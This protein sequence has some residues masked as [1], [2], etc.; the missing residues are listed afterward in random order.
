MFDMFASLRTS[1][2]VVVAL[3]FFTSEGAA[4]STPS[5]GTRPLRVTRDMRIDGVANS[6][7]PVSWLAVER[8]GGIV[9]GQPQDHTLRFF[10]S[11]GALVESFGRQG[12]GP[13]EFRSVDRAG[14]LADTLW[15]A[16]GRQPRMTLVSPQHQLIRT[17]PLPLSLLP[18]GTDTTSH[19]QLLKALGLYAD[20]SQLILGMI[21]PAPGATRPAWAQTKQSTNSPVFL[22]RVPRTGPM[23]VVAWTPFDECGISMSPVSV[24]CSRPLADF[25]PDATRL[26]FATVAASGPD[27]GTFRL[28][29]LTSYGDTVFSRR[30]PYQSE[31]V[32]SRIIDSLTAL[33]TPQD[34]SYERLGPAASQRLSRIYPPI[35]KLIIGIDGSVWVELRAKNGQRPYLVVDGKGTSI[36][37]A[38][39]TDNTFIRAATRTAVWATEKDRDDVESIVRYRVRQ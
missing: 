30:Y 20:G 38:V 8:N 27:S 6:L 5:S 17:V 7:A 3:T 28:T 11:T 16:D 23:R 24:L 39:F 25:G 10:N 1:A 22:A 34:K 2:L 36:G 32:P 19:P 14:W 13:G 4:Q 35:T 18:P 31:P 21:S 9:V 12:S 29:L 37:T 33:A 26:A 15:V